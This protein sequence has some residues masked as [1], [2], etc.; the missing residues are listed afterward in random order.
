MKKF[1]SKNKAVSF[2]FLIGVICITIGLSYAFFTANFLGLKD[3]ELTIGQNLI[4][5]YD[6]TGDALNLTNDDILSDEDG[7]SQTK[8]FDFEVTQET[9]VDV[10]TSYYIYLTKDETSNLS[11][12]NVKIYL[13]DQSDNSLVGIK[14]IVNLTS[15]ETYENSYYLYET[16]ITTNGTSQ[17]DRYR[18][19]VWIDEDVNTTITEEDGVHTLERIDYTYKFTV[20]IATKE[21]PIL[22]YA[23]YSETDNS[24]TFYKTM[25]TITEG[26]TY[27]GKTATAVYTGIEE[28]TNE[29]LDETLVPWYAD[30]NYEKITS[31]VVEDEIRP[32]ST[33][34]WF[35]QFRN[36]SKFDLEKLNV[37]NVTAMDFMFGSAGRDV[38]SFTLDLSNWDVSNVTSMYAMFSSAGYNASSVILNLSGWNMASDP[39]VN[40]L[41]Y[42]TGYNSETFVIDFSS[43]DT[44]GMTDMSYMFHTCMAKTLNLSSFNTQNVTNMAGLFYNCSLLESI[45][46]GPGWNNSKVANMSYM[47]G[48]CSALTSLNL[49]SFNTQN[50][51]NMEGVFDSCS[52]LESITFGDGWNTSNVTDMSRMFRLCSLLTLNCLGWDVGKVTKYTS[53]NENASGITAPTWVN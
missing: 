35:Y 47:F 46:F 50:V 6:E 28:Y 18:L 4:F 29:G 3:N 44:S 23:V 2:L 1:I 11:D 14:T 17:T 15:H 12:S 16:S 34:V 40:S 21:M 53:F 31:V 9:D 8:Y 20:N 51:T 41:F 13:T 37:S 27:R 39:H 45:T 10:T 43:W 33:S 5:R 22:A 26:E 32:I 19:R 30:G 25:D 24:L 7:S 38:E 36:C 49:S 42:Q 48:S 52:L